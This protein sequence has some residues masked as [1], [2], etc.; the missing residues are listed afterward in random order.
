LEATEQ[1]QA[2]DAL[3]K[4]FGEIKQLEEELHRENLSLKEEIDQASYLRQS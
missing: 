3:E 4:A 1:R 2:Q